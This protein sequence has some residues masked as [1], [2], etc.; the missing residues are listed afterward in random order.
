MS[1]IIPLMIKPIFQFQNGAIKR[2]KPQA[3]HHARRNFNSK[4]VRLKANHGG[5]ITTLENNFNSKMVRL[6][7]PR[8]WSWFEDDGRF[9]FQNGAIKR[10]CGVLSE[11]CRKKFQFQN[12]AIKSDQSTHTHRS[13]SRY[14][15]SKMVRLKVCCVFNWIRVVFYFNSKMVRLKENWPCFVGASCP[16]FNSKMVRLK[17]I[18][19]PSC[20]LP[21]GISIPK[22]CD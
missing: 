8:A 14:F 20:I 7:V 15:N 12:G 17:A 4:M 11:P 3:Q 22:W 9:Q 19:S 16:D 18:N 10:K 2:T 21:F 1:G 13:P 5:R 6:K